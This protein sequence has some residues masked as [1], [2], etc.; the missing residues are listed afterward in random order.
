M[1]IFQVR[2]LAN[3]VLRAQSVCAIRLAK[4]DSTGSTAVC[5]ATVFGTTPLRVTG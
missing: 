4:S 2:V 1:R 5:D 3:G